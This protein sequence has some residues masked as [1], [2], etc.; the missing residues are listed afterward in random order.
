MAACGT[1][2]TTSTHVLMYTDTR[3]GGGEHIQPWFHWLPQ[4]INLMLANHISDSGM[5]D[6]LAL[7]LM[8]I[9]CQ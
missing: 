7:R 3:D 2:L 1:H 8:I 9:D 6:T 5:Q 4:G